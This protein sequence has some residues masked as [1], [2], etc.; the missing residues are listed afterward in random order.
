MERLASHPCAVHK[1]KLPQLF[2]AGTLCFRSSN[3]FSTTLIAA[4]A[5]ER[6]FAP[7]GIVGHVYSHHKNQWDA[8]IHPFVT[9][10]PKLLGS[11][12]T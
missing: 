4:L 1:L 11:I 6:Y 12:L 9:A 3:Q 5:V 8:S 2:P 7:L 10:A